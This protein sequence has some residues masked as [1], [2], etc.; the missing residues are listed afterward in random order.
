MAS[1]DL[2]FANLL[3]PVVLA[4]ALGV[5]ARLVRSDLEF[6]PPL[7]DALSIYL[8][9]AIGLKG[10]AE[11]SVT[12]LSEFAGPATITLALGIVTRLRPTSSCVDSGASTARMRRPWPHTT[13]RC[14]R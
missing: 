10:G 1:L 12:P 3:S 14:R 6:P 13:D 11:L 7:Y 4:F 2:L 5:V 8:L 9:L